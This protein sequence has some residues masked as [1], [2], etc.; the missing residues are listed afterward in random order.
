MTTALLTSGQLPDG[1]A[2]EASYLGRLLLGAGLEGPSAPAVGAERFRDA[3]A[4]FAI[5]TARNRQGPIVVLLGD[6]GSGS[7]FCRA[8]LLA[9][10]GPTRSREDYVAAGTRLKA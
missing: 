4:P 3:F 10:A 5:N 9:Q 1:V 2:L 7:P 6:V 8:D